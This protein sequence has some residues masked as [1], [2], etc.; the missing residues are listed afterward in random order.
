MIMKCKA[1][2]KW[3]LIF[4][5]LPQLFFSK[6]ENE[7][8]LIWLQFLNSYS[9]FFS[10]PKCEKAKHEKLKKTKSRKEIE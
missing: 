4:K 1:V 9:S 10:C 3:L 5:M 6:E 7:C 8:I 2:L